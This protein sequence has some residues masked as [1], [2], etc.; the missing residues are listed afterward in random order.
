MN[1]ELTPA[2]AG[3]LITVAVLGLGLLLWGALRGR[4]GSGAPQ[5]AREVVPVREQITGE[6][7]SQPAAAQPMS[8]AEARKREALENLKFGATHGG[9]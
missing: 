5:A 4:M 2:K 9:R 8:D 6:V 7:V 3:L 1:Q